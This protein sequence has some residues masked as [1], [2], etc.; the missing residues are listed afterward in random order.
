MSNDPVILSSIK[1]KRP[2]RDDFC[3]DY[4]DVYGRFYRV[5]LQEEAH[6]KLTYF[7]TKIPNKYWFKIVQKFARFK[8][9]KCFRS[10]YLK[11]LKNIK[12]YNF[13]TNKWWDLAT[14]PNNR[15]EDLHI[16][17][18]QLREIMDRIEGLENNYDSLKWDFKF[19]SD[20]L[21]EWYPEIYKELNFNEEL[22]HYPHQIKDYLQLKIYPILT[23]KLKEIRGETQNRLC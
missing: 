8:K 15:V 2:G 11:Y 16:P 14:T 20:D 10:L 3:E 12:M 22:N 5:T 13:W 17:G 21:K 9:L 4:D 6:K 1:H 19:I 18:K 23:I 7:K